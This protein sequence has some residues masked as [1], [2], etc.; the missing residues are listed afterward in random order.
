MTDFD[1]EVAMKNPIAPV[2]KPTERE[3]AAVA[4]FFYEERGRQP[5]HEVEDWLRAEAHVCTDKKHV[6]RTKENTTVGK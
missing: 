1:G 5:G 4:Y 3:I 6:V 2:R